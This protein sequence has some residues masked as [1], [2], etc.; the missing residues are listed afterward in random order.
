MIRIRKYN[1]EW[2]L[3]WRRYSG[4]KRTWHW[5][6]V[7]N[8]DQLH[9]QIIEFAAQI[10]NCICIAQEVMSGKS[11]VYVY[12]NGILRC[13]HPEIYEN[14]PKGR[15]ACL[16]MEMRNHEEIETTIQLI[17]SGVWKVRKWTPP[18]SFYG[19]NEY[20]F[21]QEKVKQQYLIVETRNDK[22]V[23][24]EVII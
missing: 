19:R 6:T 24:F 1:G 15:Y 22:F 7:N 10:N 5:G 9:Q 20:C 3:R 21:S 14:A 16:T 23:P 18:P 8:L 11:D 17:E 2:Q 13:K 4:E 12:T